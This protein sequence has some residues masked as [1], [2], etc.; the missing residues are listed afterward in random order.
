MTRALP[1]AEMDLL[2]QYVTA[3]GNFG[4]NQAESTVLLHVT[5]SNLNV[6]FMELRLDKHV[7][8]RTPNLQASRAAHSSV[9][10]RC[11]LRRV[12]TAVP[13]RQQALLGP[14]ESGGSAQRLQALLPNR[15]A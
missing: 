11:G 8:S 1:S 12:H 7:R 5:H 13:A 9:R 14:S 15:L 4:A 3:D 6:Q 2:R 10:L